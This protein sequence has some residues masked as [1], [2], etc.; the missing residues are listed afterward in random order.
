MSHWVERF[1]QQLHAASSKGDARQ[2]LESYA[3]T[4][5]R[6]RRRTTSSRPATAWPSFHP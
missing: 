6:A 1:L 5:C 3:E 4:I 2:A